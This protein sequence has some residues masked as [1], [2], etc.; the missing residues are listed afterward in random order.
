V[1][2][3]MANFHYPGDLLPPTAW[4][5]VNTSFDRISDPVGPRGGVPSTHG[6]RVK[7]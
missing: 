1:L 6:T 7:P 4:E 3:L 2:A 5:A